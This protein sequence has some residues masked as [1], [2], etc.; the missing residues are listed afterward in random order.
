MNRQ[1]AKSA[2]E[3]RYGAS[4]ISFESSQTRSIFHLTWRSWRLGGENLFTLPNGVAL[5]D[6]PPGCD[7]DGGGEVETGSVFKILENGV[8]GLGADV[9]AGYGC[10]GCRKVVFFPSTRSPADHVFPL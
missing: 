7:G 8:L 2:K 5:R 3:T 6:F 10:S 9:G 4:E 1:D